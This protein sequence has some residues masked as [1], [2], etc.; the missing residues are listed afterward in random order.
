MEQV[1]KHVAAT[2]SLIISFLQHKKVILVPETK[3]QK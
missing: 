1:I 3:L 2:S